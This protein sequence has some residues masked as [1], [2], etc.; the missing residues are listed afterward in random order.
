MIGADT[1]GAARRPLRWPLALADIAL[2][3]ACALLLAPRDAGMA[4]VAPPA[5]RLAPAQVFEPGEAR[6]RPGAAARIAALVRGDQPAR[7]IAITV[8]PDARGATLRLD[9]WEL[10]A[11]RTAAI[12]RALPP[13]AHP[14]LRAPGGAG[15]WVRIAV[16]AP[17]SATG[18]AF[19]STTASRAA[20]CGTISVEGRRSC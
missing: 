19:A 14:L 10:A 12:A 9:A 5:L 15:G 4:A 20:D 3:V 17:G 13:D 1:H 16:I 18:T 6:L 11:A 2:L 7:R 8:A